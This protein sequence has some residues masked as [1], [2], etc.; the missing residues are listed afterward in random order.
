MDNKSLGVGDFNSNVQKHFSSDRIEKADK[1]RVW[2]K[3]PKVK[4]G[5][6]FAYRLVNNKIDIENEEQGNVMGCNRENQQGCSYSESRIGDGE[7]QFRSG[8]RF[9]SDGLR[10]RIFSTET[11]RNIGGSKHADVSDFLRRSSIASAKAQQVELIKWAEKN[12]C[13]FGKDFYVGFGEQLESGTE[14]HVFLDKNNT[15][16]VVKITNYKKNDKSPLAFLENRITLHNLIFPQTAYKFV[17]ILSYGGTF[18]FITEQPFIVGETP[19]GR[20]IDMYLHG[21]GF[22]YNFDEDCYCKPIEYDKV[23]KLHDTHP[24]NF[25]KDK[26]GNIFC[27]DSVLEI[28]EY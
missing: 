6:Y 7:N 21:M 14:A 5:G 20:E 24:G 28:E 22:R 8:A 2:V 10:G 4:G 3:N 11:R 16:R 19:D 17:G 13:L 1:K 18:R 27:I 26:D 23:L 15:R 12:G 25:L 9:E